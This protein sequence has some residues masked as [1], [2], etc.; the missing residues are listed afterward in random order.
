MLEK[1]VNIIDKHTEKFF[2]RDYNTA[3][4]VVVKVCGETNINK[5]REVL[6]NIKNVYLTE[7][8]RQIYDCDISALMIDVELQELFNELK[9]IPHTVIDYTNDVFN[10]D[11]K[12]YYDADWSNFFELSF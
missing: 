2:C 12:K 5:F 10:Y 11:N 8:Y 7:T 4:V 1:I 9:E 6:V 3:C